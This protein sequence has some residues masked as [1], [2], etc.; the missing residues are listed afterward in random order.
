MKLKVQVID[1]IEDYENEMRRH[2]DDPS[3]YDKPQVKIT[4]NDYNISDELIL[5]YKVMFDKETG[6]DSICIITD[7]DDIS[8]LMVDYHSK[9]ETELEKIIEMRNNRFKNK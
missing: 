2:I 7:L 6:K 5:A 1:D 3:I 9:V 4:Y 8:M